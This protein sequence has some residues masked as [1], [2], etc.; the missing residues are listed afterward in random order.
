MKNSGRVDRDTDGPA[1]RQV[2][3]LLTQ[4]LPDTSFFDF[5]ALNTL[6]FSLSSFEMSTTAQRSTATRPSHIVGVANV[7]T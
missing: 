3:Q 6:D 1:V 4:S 2:Q 5:V 7:Y